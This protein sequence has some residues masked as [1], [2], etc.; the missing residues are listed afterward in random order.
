MR[1]NR[2][3]AAATVVTLVVTAPNHAIASSGS[4]PARHG[5]AVPDLVISA[6]STEATVTNVGD[7]GAK[8]RQSTPLPLLFIGCA[9]I[10]IADVLRDHTTFVIV[11]HVNDSKGLL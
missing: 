11:L 4:T 10:E 6:T 5:A 8:P 2:A 9:G 3:A 7:A 1:Y